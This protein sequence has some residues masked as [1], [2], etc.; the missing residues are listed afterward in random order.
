MPHAPA[1]PP[2]QTPPMPWRPMTDAEWAA[3]AACL[4]QGGAGRPARDARRSWDGIFWIACSTGPWRDLPAAFGRADSVH[5]T[6][7][8]AAA[9]RQLHRMLLR[10]AAHPLLADRALRG[11]AWFVERAFRRAFRVAPRAI[12]FARHL[13]LLAALPAAPC[14]LPRPDLSEEAHAIARRWFD[15]GPGRPF[16]FLPILHRLFRTVWGEPRQWRSTG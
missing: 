11:I 16:G 15:L 10:V 6:L 5:R 2:R 4:R 14:W 8:R 9:A 7:R 1:L 13:G 12:V 3:V